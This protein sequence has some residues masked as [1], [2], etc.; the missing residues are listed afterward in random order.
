LTVGSLTFALA[1]C[2]VMSTT[3]VYIV[4]CNVV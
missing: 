4:L 2:R 1:L 3:F